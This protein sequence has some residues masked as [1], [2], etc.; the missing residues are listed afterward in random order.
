MT[1]HPG[2]AIRNSHQTITLERGAMSRD[3]SAAI[4]DQRRHG[5]RPP[6]EF[7]VITNG[8]L[9]AVQVIRPTPG[10]HS[11]RFSLPGAHLESGM[12]NTARHAQVQRLA[13]RSHALPLKEGAMISQ[14]LRAILLAGL[15]VFPAT[16]SAPIGVP[17]GIVFAQ[18]GPVPCGPGPDC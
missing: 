7:L 5:G 3:P 9:R 4:P 2:L 12:P 11:S 16:A 13:R 15:L 8:V 17:G 14:A 10:G 6:A 18:T 1:E